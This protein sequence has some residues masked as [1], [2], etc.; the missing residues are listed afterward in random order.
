MRNAA[1]R[2]YTC[3]VPIPWG[4]WSIFFPNYSTWGI[5][6]PPIIP[7]IQRCRRR[8]RPSTRSSTDR[9]RSTLLPPRL[10]SAACSTRWRARPIYFPNPLER[11]RADECASTAADDILAT[12]GLVHHL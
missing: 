7:W 4:R 10:I 3:C 9:D 11:N 6:P 8:N 12:N 1:E 2:R 5:L